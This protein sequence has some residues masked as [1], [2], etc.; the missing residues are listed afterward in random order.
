VESHIK[1]CGKCGKVQGDMVA[2]PLG[3]KTPKAINECEPC[4]SLKTFGLT[5]ELFSVAE[6]LYGQNR[7]KEVFMNFDH[8]RSDIDNHFEKDQYLKSQGQFKKISLCKESAKIFPIWGIETGKR[9]VKNST[10]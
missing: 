1:V 8:Y 9:S 3:L 5:H 2:K 6:E 10:D 7:L 4:G